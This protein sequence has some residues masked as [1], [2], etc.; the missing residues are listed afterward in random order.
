[1]VKERSKIRIMSKCDHA[2]RK[3]AME[4]EDHAHLGWKEIGLLYQEEQSK[5]RIMSKWN[6]V[7]R[8]VAM[9]RDLGRLSCLAASHVRQQ[10]TE[11]DHLGWKEIDISQYHGYKL[12]NHLKKL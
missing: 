5:I 9:E 12:P 11:I 7:D 2:Y 4:K 8:K 1:M 6:H 3:V 10:C